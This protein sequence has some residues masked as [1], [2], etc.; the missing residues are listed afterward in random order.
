MSAIDWPY[1][2]LCIYLYVHTRTREPCKLLRLI[3][4]KRYIYIYVHTETIF[5]NENNFLL[6]WWIDSITEQTIHGSKPVPLVWSSGERRSFTGWTI[7][8]CVELSRINW[9][10]EQWNLRYP[11]DYVAHCAPRRNL[12]HRG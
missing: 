9:N 11:F 12:A 2:R 5:I 1:Y 8:Y 10:G 3:G 6:R 4:Y 7:N